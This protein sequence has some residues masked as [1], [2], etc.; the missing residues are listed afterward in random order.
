MDIII[1]KDTSITIS[2]LP[3]TANT[4]IMTETILEVDLDPNIDTIDAMSI[5]VSTIGTEFTITENPIPL[6]MV[7]TMIAP[8]TAIIMKSIAVAIITI[9]PVMMTATEESTTILMTTQEY[10]TTEKHIIKERIA[11]V[12]RIITVEREKRIQ[13]EEEMHE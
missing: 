10:P 8:L 13:E 2:F 7:T 9:L 4:P 5:I 6:S 3:T 11:T 1:Q 12:M